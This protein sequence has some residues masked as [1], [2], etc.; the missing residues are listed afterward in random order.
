MVEKGRTRTNRLRGTGSL[1]LRGRIW[2]IRYWVRGGQVQESS[3]SP[4]RLVAERL[5]QRRLVALEDGQDVRP[6]VEKTRFDDLLQLIRDDYLV[7]GR[8]SAERLETSIKHLKEEFAGFK[9]I[10]ITAD[11]VNSYKSARLKAGAAPASINAELAA[12]RRMFNLALEA[13]RVFKVPKIKALSVQNARQGFFEE[14]DLKRV[15]THLPPRIRPIA[16]FA[17]RSGWRLREVTGLRWEDVDLE[18]GTVRLEARRSK[19]GEGRVLPIREVPEL[20]ELLEAR[21]LA[22]R[23]L[24]LRT[25]QI[26]PWVFSYGEGV[27]GRRPGEQI[28]RFHGVWNKACAAAGCPGKLFHDLRRSAVRNLERAGVPRSTAMRV[29]GH[30]TEDVYRRYAIVSEADMAECFVSASMGQVQGLN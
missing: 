27:R 6:Q 2:W 7:N 11:R 24:E 14:A 15:L 10:N 4:E 28:R 13:E 21:R 3:G 20:I 19:N 1:R 30:R 9:A 5:L 22:T 12:L 8:R 25:G 18:S 17:F 23:K 16:T 29:T 26:I